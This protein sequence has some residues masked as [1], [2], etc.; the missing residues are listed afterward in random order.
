MAETDNKPNSINILRGVFR[1]EWILKNMVFFLFLSLLAIIYIANGHLS[2]KTIRQ[3]NAINNELKELQYV[4]KTLKTEEMQKSG[5]AQIVKAT[6]P[7]GLKVSNEMPVR[8]KSD[9]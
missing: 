4:Y 5:E 1:Y 9:K 6:A 7:L 8:I 2:D 3:I